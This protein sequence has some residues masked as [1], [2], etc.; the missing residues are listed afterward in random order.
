MEK[1]IEKNKLVKTNIDEA[2]ARIESWKGKNVKYELLTKGITNPNYK[3]TVDGEDFFLKIPGAGTEAFIDRDNC[4]KA[5]LIGMGTGIG[6]EV[7]HYFEDT[8]VE[9]WEWL[10]NHRQVIFGDI[11][12]EKI[13]RKIGEAARKFH[14]IDGVILPVKQTLFEQAW[15]MIDLAKNGGYLPPWYDRMVFLLKEIEEAINADGI[16]FKPCHNDFW[17]ANFMYDDA[18]DD[19]KLIDYEYASMNDPYNDLGCFSTTNYLTEEMDVELC[20]IYHGGW[21][22]KGFAKMKLYKIV[23][24]IK[25]GFWA[26]QQY[27]NSDVKFDFMDWYGMKVARLQHLWLDP[28]VDYWLNLLKGRPLFRQ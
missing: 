28:R 15:Q 25:W 4:H 2:I 6:P 12:N 16:D 24:D 3:V 7:L 18:A 27:L 1:T 17:T 14:N 26:L 11:Y 8:G 5:N 20:K 23:A 19:F 13:F 21:D 10:P 22:E 9:V